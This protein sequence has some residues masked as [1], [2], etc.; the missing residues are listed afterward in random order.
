MDT[1]LSKQN[2]ELLA[3]LSILSPLEQLGKRLYEGTP[4]QILQPA[5]TE[6]E[7]EQT[8]A[9]ATKFGISLNAQN[10][11]GKYGSPFFTSVVTENRSISEL[12]DVSVGAHPRFLGNAPHSHDYFEII[13]ICRGKATQTFADE[14]LNM[15][16]GDLCILCPGF[17]HDISSFH[18]ENIILTIRL[19]QSAFDHAFFSL[20]SEG[21]IISKYFKGV[22]YGRNH[23]PYLLFR[24]GNDPV[25]MSLCLDMYRETEQVRDYSRS[26]L[27]VQSSMLFLRLLREHGDKLSISRSTDVIKNTTPLLILQYIRSN[28]NIVTLEMVA[29][30]FHYST[31]YLSRMFKVNFGHS[32]TDL[33]TE[34]RLYNAKEMLINTSLAISEI[35]Q[36]VGYQ[37]PSHFFRV[38]KSFFG[39]APQEYRNKNPQN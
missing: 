22:L 33:R 14:T 27:S 38:F 30:E 25:I 26:Y 20:F 7:L 16:T 9:L 21:D 29:K 11:L 37:S 17:P 3:K 5:H 39:K 18:E 2:T 34:L 8:I 28:Y 6:D 19:R 15:E 31:S 32:F 1:I 36:A 24:T 13:Y 35:A 12:L 4:S 23:Y 10:Y